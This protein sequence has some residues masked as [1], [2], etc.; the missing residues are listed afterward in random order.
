MKPVAGV[1]GSLALSLPGA[2]LSAATVEYDLTIT[3]QAINFTGH[4]VQA[5][6]SMANCR[7]RPCDSLRATVP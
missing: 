5:M 7:G 3:R 6:L 2:M 4:P 1:L